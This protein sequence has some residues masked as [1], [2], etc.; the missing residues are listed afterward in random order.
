MTKETKELL[1][2]F[3]ERTFDDIKHINE[4]DNEYWEA[5]ELMEVLGYSKWGNFNKVIN[6]AKI[7][8]YSIKPK[9][10]VLKILENST[11]MVIKDYIMEKPLNKS[12][13]EKAST[14][15]KKIY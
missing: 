1:K 3:K 8:L 11:T 7:K 10:Q 9:S 15:K 5:R 4:H 14:M 2:E 12:L 6:K 13:I